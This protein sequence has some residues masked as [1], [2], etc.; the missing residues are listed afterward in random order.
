M[1]AVMTYN[2]Y[3]TVAVVGGAGLGY[4]CFALFDLPSKVLGNLTSRPAKWSAGTS[5]PHLSEGNSSMYC[6]SYGTAGSVLSPIGPHVSSQ[7]QQG[8]LS[9]CGAALGE[10]SVHEGDRTQ[11]TGD[12]EG[13]K[14]A[15]SV[16][17]SGEEEHEGLRGAS[18]MVDVSDRTCLLPQET[19]KVEV[20]VHAL[21][22]E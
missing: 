1:L 2:A 21:S 13:E 22:E 19:I 17:M 5:L 6:P 20:Q 11:V 7:L 10:I 14:L 8:S 9:M 4:Y 15:P 3:F 12:A 16:V 18:V